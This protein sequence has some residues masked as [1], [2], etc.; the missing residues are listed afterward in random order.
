MEP[1]PTKIIKMEV[2]PDILLNLLNINNPIQF[3]KYKK[4]TKPL[5]TI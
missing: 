5:K 2:T 4:H 1:W 3:L